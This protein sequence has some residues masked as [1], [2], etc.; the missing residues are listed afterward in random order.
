M[1]DFIKPLTRKAEL[2]VVE[3][4]GR[5]DSSSEMKMNIGP[6]VV[7]VSHAWK[8]S[9]AGTVDA[10]DQWFE[11]KGQNGEASGGGDG[12]GDGRTLDHERSC[13][14]WFD[15][16][17]V[18]Q[19]ESA[20]ATFTKEF[21]YTEFRQ[22]IE[23]IGR[24]VITLMPMLDPLPLKRSWCCWE[25]FCTIDAGLQFETALSRR[26]QRWR[27]THTMTSSMECLVES[28][29]AWNSED[30]A[31]ILAACRS[32]PGWLLCRQCSNKASICI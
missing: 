17:T 18:N 5:H 24:T 19:H 2:S 28:A 14:V 27:D 9:F 6:A 31:K 26:D 25:I 4:L 15:I 16:C 22:G 20:Q 1:E 10:L 11:K 21:F 12:D 8:L 32:V 7:F 13:F 3:L 29:E 30:Q 23:A